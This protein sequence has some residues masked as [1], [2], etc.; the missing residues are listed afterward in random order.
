[1]S[2]NMPQGKNQI[3]RLTFVVAAALT[4]GGCLSDESPVDDGAGPTTGN[5]SGNSP[6]SISGTPKT[7]ALVGGVYEFRPNASDSDG[8]PLTF[9]IDNKPRWAD[10]DSNSGRLAG[11]LS[12]GDE[13]IYEGIRIN[14]SDG[15]SQRSLPAFSVTVSA[16]A[17]GSMTL[18]WTAPSENTDGSALTDLAGYNIYYGESPGVYPNRIRINSPGITTYVVENLLPTT[19]YVVATSFNAAGVESSFSNMATKTVTP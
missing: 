14:V 6:P 2:S 8:D 12:L 3:L 9:S 18:S 7:S 16:N 15:E 4:I 5:A 19:Y 17:D 11:E 1:M 10:F 13:G